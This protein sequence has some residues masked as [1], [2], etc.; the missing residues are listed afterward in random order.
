M[1]NFK[2]VLALVLTVAM[3]LSSMTF[4]FAQTVVQNQEKAEVLF[5]LGLFKGANPDKFE[6]RLENDMNRAEAVTMVIRLLGWDT[7]AT[8]EIPFKDK[9]LSGDYAWAKP[10]IAKAYEEGITIGNSATEFGVVEKVTLQQYATFLLRALGYE[11]TAENYAQAP[12]MAYEA[13]LLSLADV[14]AADKAAIRDQLVGVSYN[15]LFASEKDSDV[16]LLEKLIADEKVTEDQVIKSGDADLIALLEEVT[17]GEDLAIASVVADNLK[18]VYVTFNREVDADTVTDANVKVKDNKGSVALKEDGVT[19][20]ITLDKAFEDNQK[21][22]TL[23]VE[24][25]KDAE[26]NKIAKTEEKFKAFDA[27]LP[28]VLDVAVTGPRQVV[29]TFSEPINPNSKDK[30]VEV[31][32]DKANLGNRVAV[33]GNKVT[34]DV[35]TNFVEDKEYTVRVTG[36]EDYA[37]YKNVVNTLSFV[38]AKD[39]NPPVATVV[40]AEQ[41]YVVIEFDKPVKGLKVDKFYHTFNA[42]EAQGIYPKAKA[43]GVSPIKST[44]SVT[45]VFVYFYENANGKAIPA[46]GTTLGIHGK[47]IKDNWGNALGTQEFKISV[48]ADNTTPEVKE[49][50]VE[51]NDKIKV[52]FTKTVEFTKDNIDVLDAD[53]KKA[54]GL[55]VRSIDKTRGT[56]F[57]VTLSKEMAGKTITVSIKDVKDTTVNKNKLDLYSQLVEIVD[58]SKP[59]VKEVYYNLKLKSGETKKFDKKDLF[60][61]FNKEVDPETALVASNYSV[62]LP[63]NEVIV[64][65]ESP[66]FDSV[67]TRVKLSLTDAQAKKI[68][69]VSNKTDVKLQVINV[70]DLLGNTIVPVQKAFK[71]DLQ[72]DTTKTIAANIEVTAK[73][74]IKVIFKDLLTGITEDNFTVTLNEKVVASEDF[75]SFTITENNAETVVEIKLSKE[76]IATD[77]GNLNVAVDAK[78]NITNS[79]GEKVT[80]VSISET[81]D[82]V[83]PEIDKG[84]DN[85]NVTIVNTNNEKL[86]VTLLLTEKINKTTVATTS[87]SVSKGSIDKVDAETDKKV[88]LTITNSDKGFKAGDIIDLTYEGK[89]LDI[90]GNALKDPGLIELNVPT[91]E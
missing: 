40:K 26:G 51:A 82:K 5:D 80:S 52:I 24:N 22:Y 62:V 38:Y 68:H 17:T 15:A 90:P 7:D 77:L 39:S 43:D 35:F 30:K 70:K 86:T 75:A 74:T 10:F 11:I 61:T 66:S 47:E 91:A 31:K 28:E 8:A 56:E 54:S 37:G 44:D 78:T 9:E 57:V 6:P 23:I 76:D 3:V 53:G 12:E 50:K 4:A 48:A 45:K 14:L 33:D 27:T 18:E 19:A 72:G 46:G 73:D 55:S 42:W 32:Q 41:E 36:F 13:G 88:V 58:K 71:T 69:D 63:D 20:V 67:S 16:T 83:V 1:K 59:E 34:V 2:K 21:E 85:A 89:I 87:F 81:K 25:V 65:T 84:K 29:L 49:I 79:F 64:L 60:V